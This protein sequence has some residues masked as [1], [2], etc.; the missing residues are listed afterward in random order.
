MHFRKG[1]YAPQQTL[2][3]A[4]MLLYCR[5]SFHSSALPSLDLD[6]DCKPEVYGSYQTI[7]ADGCRKIRDKQH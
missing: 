6:G 4:V 1:G 2:E 7:K 5:D 3:D